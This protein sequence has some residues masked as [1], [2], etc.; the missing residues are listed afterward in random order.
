MS[1]YIIEERISHAQRKLVAT[2]T[3]I[4]EIAFEC[5]FNTISRFNAAF[6]KINSCTPREFRKRYQ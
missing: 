6:L 5:G 4:T 1:E 3:S 2:D